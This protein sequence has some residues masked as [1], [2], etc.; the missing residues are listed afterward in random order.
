MILSIRACPPLGADDGV[1]RLE[2]VLERHR[3]HGQPATQGETQLEMMFSQGHGRLPQA[4]AVHI[5]ALAGRCAMAMN[6][7]QFQ[8][9]LSQMP[10]ADAVLPA[11]SGSEGTRQGQAWRDCDCRRPLGACAT[12]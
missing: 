1:L 5:Y 10:R 11:R 7:V 6:R 4:S 12:G 8:R 2:A 3:P 9:E